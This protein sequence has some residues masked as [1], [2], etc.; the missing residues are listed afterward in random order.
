MLS[1]LLP[2]PKHSTYLQPVLVATT[3]VSERSGSSLGSKKRSNEDGEK[4]YNSSTE[5]NLYSL[6]NTNVDLNQRV[7][8]ATDI[9]TRKVQASYEDSIPL[10]KRYPNLKHHFPRYTLETCPDDSVQKCVSETKQVIDELLGFNK[11]DTEKDQKLSIKYSTGDADEERTIQI[12]TLQEDPMLPPKFKLRK[13]RHR[14]PSPPPPIL[15]DT[16]SA[17]Q[18]LTKED[19]EKWKIPAAVSNWKNNQGFALSLEDRISAATAGEE[20]SDNPLNVEKFSALSN[21]LEN[22]DKEARVE[23]TMRNKMRQEQA[24]KEQREKEEKL[25]ELAVL[26]RNDKY[27]RREHGSGEKRTRRQ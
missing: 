5:L 16:S 14:E 20:A 23:I 3:N 7:I 2:R 26:A 24:L 4:T 9:A 10:K 21:A 13:N 19:R 18:K 1:S 17:T 12:R 6:P 22:A 27:R 15:K 25:R 11:V 8:S